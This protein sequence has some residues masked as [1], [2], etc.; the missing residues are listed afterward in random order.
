[1]KAFILR[2]YRIKPPRRSEKTE[3]IIARFRGSID[4]QS[5]DAQV[6]YPL[7]QQA[8]QEIIDFLKPYTFVAFENEFVSRLPGGRVFGEGVVI[9]PDGDSIA[10]DVSV[11]Y[12]KPFEKH[13]LQEHERLPRPVRISGNT[14]VIATKGGANYY[15]WLFDELPRLLISGQEALD[16]IIGHTS[17]PFNREGLRRYGF[18]GKVISVVPEL[19]VRCDVLVVPSFVGKTG[20][21]VPK[22]VRL[23]TNFVDSIPRK[24]SP[25]GERIYLSREKAAI[26]RVSNEM[27][28]WPQLCGRGFKKVIL[29]DLAWEEQINAFRNAKVVVAPHGAGLS[30]LMFCSSG[31]KVVELFNRSY[32]HWCFWQLAAIK[33]LDYRPVVSSA[34]DPLMHAMGKYNENVEVDVRQTLAIVDE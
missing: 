22:Q 11:D 4:F 25:F 14:L 24:T 27:E 15:H 12:G 31:T 6:E 7:P 17:S 33:G 1:M 5:H 18:K 10:R 21:P 23:I 3:D 32:M 29:E 8:S 16:N 20:H 26:R 2:C 9:S 28:L 30:N 19:H 34:D 13:Y